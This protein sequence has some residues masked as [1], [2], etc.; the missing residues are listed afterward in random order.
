[1][2]MKS[3]G[4]STV[5]LHDRSEIAETYPWSPTHEQVEAYIRSLE[6]QV[7]QKDIGTPLCHAEE[8]RAAGRATRPFAFSYIFWGLIAVALGC[9]AWLIQIIYEGLK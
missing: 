9:F 3:R 4:T 1:M 7:L 6:W 8:Y 5:G 2:E